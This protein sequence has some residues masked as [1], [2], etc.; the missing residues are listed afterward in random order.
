MLKALNNPPDAVKMTFTCV[1]HLL[2][3]VSSDVPVDRRGRL[4]ADNPWKVAQKQM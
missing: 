1:L 4:T 2:S 3:G